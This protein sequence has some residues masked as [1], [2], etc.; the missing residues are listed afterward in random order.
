MITASSAIV[1]AFLAPGMDNTG[2]YRS[3][4][5]IEYKKICRDQEPYA[6]KVCGRLINSGVTVYVQPSL[7]NN[8]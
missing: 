8:V 1:L 7:Y 6:L 4:F 2:K 3:F 5:E